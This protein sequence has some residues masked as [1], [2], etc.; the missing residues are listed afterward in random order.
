[1][2]ILR[3]AFMG[4]LIAALA[5]CSTFPGVGSFDAELTATENMTTSGTA[6][7]KAL[8]R[9]YGE[10][11]RIYYNNSEMAGVQSFNR[12]AAA[13]GSTAPSSTAR[14]WLPICRF[15]RCVLQIWTAIG[16]TTSSA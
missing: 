7:D 15:G 3:V 13:A 14:T 1:M 16:S 8:H 4:A 5:A 6:F 2:T 10:V 11:A 12:R 9:E